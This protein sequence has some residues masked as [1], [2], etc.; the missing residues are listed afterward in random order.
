M[1]GYLIT[2]DVLS[3]SQ[4]LQNAQYLVNYDFPWNP[5]WF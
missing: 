1:G 2:T 3:E 5:P 4:N